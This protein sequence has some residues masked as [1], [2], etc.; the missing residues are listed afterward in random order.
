MQGE[1]CPAKAGPQ[2]EA[3]LARRRVTVVVKR[4]MIKNSIVVIDEIRDQVGAGKQPYDAV[5]ESAL[6]R[7]RPVALAAATTVL[8][9]APP[10]Y[11]MF[12][13]VRGAEAA[14]KS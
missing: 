13:D 9:V 8:G 7:V 5:I 4:M 10:L 2:P 3:S 12:Y 11:A 1:F 14:R 6:G